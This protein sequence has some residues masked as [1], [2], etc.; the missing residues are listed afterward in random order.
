MYKVDGISTEVDCTAS[1]MNSGLVQ[2]T[3]DIEMSEVPFTTL[4]FV[5]TRLHSPAFVRSCLHTTKR[6]RMLQLGIGQRDA[7]MAASK[8]NMSSEGRLLPRGAVGYRQR[9]S[10]STGVARSRATESISSAARGSSPA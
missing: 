5:R 10:I 3:V 2:S 4:H 9:T 8:T 6:C 7:R 1:R